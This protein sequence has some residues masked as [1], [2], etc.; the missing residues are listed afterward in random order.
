ME[1]VG[2]PRIAVLGCGYWG[3]NLVRNFRD[4]GALSLVCDVASSGRESARAIAPN[5]EC[6]E[7]FESAFSR[8][9]IDA[10]VLA[11]PAETHE[12]LTVRAVRAGKDVYVEKPMALTVAQGRNMLLEATTHDRILMV[13]HILEYHP[14]VIKLRELIER[15][16]L[17]QILYIFSNRLNFGKIRSE[18]NA[19]WSFAPHDIAVILRL[20][21][22]SP[23]EVTSVGGNF[24]NPSLADV[25]VSCLRFESGQRAHVFVSWLNP[26]KEQ[27]LV[28]VGKKKMA[29]FNDMNAK[30]KLVL[31]D[32]RVDI[33]S[34][35]PVLRKGEVE[36][37]K[38][39]P[40]EPL[41][42]ECAHFLSCVSSRKVPTTDGQSGIEVLRVLE[43]CQTSLETSGA[44]VLLK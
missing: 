6:S 19:L 39:E 28:I 8:Q 25:T 15:D 36:V 30:E 2:L 26:F 35:I 17:G 44:P 22:T 24:V 23:I 34:E 11:T 16:E 32:Q 3:K 38:L 13:G 20:L 27:K 29:V 18:E 10:V 33:E 21:G 40:I 43:A 14:A 37:V 1:N 41:R 42:E 31:H 7:S 5:I 12:E 9:D 4:L